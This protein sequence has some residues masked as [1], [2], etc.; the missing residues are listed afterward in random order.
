[1]SLQEIAGGITAA[2]GFVAA[3]VAAG[4]KKEAGQLDVA[5][6]YSPEPATAAGVF[7]QNR[8]QGAPVIVSREHL[9]SGRARAIVATSGVA[10]TCTGVRG[11]ADAREM[12]VLAGGLLKI[13]PSEVAVASTGVIG[14]PLPMEKVRHG[15]AAAAASL[16][17]QGGTQAVRAIMTTDTRPKEVALRATLGGVPVTVGG[18]AKGAGMIHPDLAT[19]LVFLATD[20]AVSPEMLRRS[21]RLA[22]DTTFNMLT[23][24]GDTSPNDMVVVLANGRAGNQPL[25]APGPAW[26]EFTRLLEEACVRLTRMLAADAEG[27]TRLIEVRVRGAATL[28]DARTAARAVAGS[29]LVK[30]AVFGR[31]AN[32][33]RIINAVGYSGASFTPEAVD[34]VLASH[35]GQEQVARGGCGLAFDEERA[36]EILGGP[37]VRVIIDLHQGE[38][39]ATAFGCD[40]S[41]DYVRINAD[42]RS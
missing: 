20:A 38:A 17:P 39:V 18:M 34:I 21:L 22:A 36:R 35:A 23:V 28:A 11:L 19:M 26:E 15:I 13:P 7:T 31:D 10:N 42:Y 27:A 9:A 1:M 32:W 30:A 2:T 24:D 37:E 4:I 25:T 12:A 6:V 5:M 29:N 40:L 41:Y 3:G 8:L 33:G 16:S 14:V